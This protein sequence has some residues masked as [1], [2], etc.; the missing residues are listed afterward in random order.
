V[1]EGFKGNMRIGIDFDNTI[2]NYA[3][4]FT[5]QALRLGLLKPGTENVTKQFVR[6]SIKELPDGG[7]KWCKLQGNVYGKFVN[8][9][10]PFEGVLDFIKK[11]VSKKI[12]VFIVSH[13][14][15]YAQ[16]IEEKINLREAAL[17]WLQNNKFLN[18]DGSCLNESQIF[19]EDPRES[20][21]N[22]I[23]E[24]QCTH[25]IDDLEEVLLEPSFPENVEKILFSSQVEL[26]DKKPFKVC[27]HWREIEGWI[28]QYAK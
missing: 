24:L 4:V 20:K 18:A 2:I 10:K 13:K 8:D 21:I 9:A 17:G 25:F 15:K 22:R 6:D 1:E 7:K 26:S 3:N 5:Q 23:K 28:F 16:A 19:F 11:C 27:D 14:T 12:D